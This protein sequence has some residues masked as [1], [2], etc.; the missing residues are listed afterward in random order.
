MGQ[1]RLDVRLIFLI[2]TALFLS[3]CD[4]TSSEQMSVTLRVTSSVGGTVTANTNADGDLELNCGTEGE[5]CSLD[6]PIDS[7]VQLE[8]KADTEFAFDAWEGCASETPIC[9]L[10]VDASRTVSASFVARES[11]EE[12]DPED[13]NPE[14]PEDPEPE[15]PNPEEPEPEEPEPEQYSLEIIL[16][17]AGTGSVTDGSSLDCGDICSASYPAG[18][19]LTLTAEPGEGSIFIGWGE[20]CDNSI[21]LSCSLTLNEDTELEAIFDLEPYALSVAV[22]GS[23]EGTVKGAS[24]A[25]DCQPNCSAELLAGTSVVLTALPETGSSFASWQGCPAPQGDTCGLELDEDTDVSARFNVISGT[26]KTV[27]VP[28]RRSSDDAEEYLK[29]VFVSAK[30]EE[31]FPKNGVDIKSGDLDFV[32]DKLTDADQIVG[33]RFSGLNIP[34]GAT[35][36]KAYIQFRSD[37]DYTNRTPT[38]LFFTA[39]ASAK[40]QT[41]VHQSVGGISSRP[42][43]RTSAVRWDPGL[44]G[45]EGVA[46]ESERSP[47]LSEIVQELVNYPDWD[48][49][50]NAIA[51]IVSGNGY[52]AATSF[53]DSDGEAQL[54]VSYR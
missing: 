35:I 33:L 41:F 3:A 18:T 49:G 1:F 19:E 7:T 43:V 38:R 13:P 17:G 8:A 46:G 23:G 6:V 50:N 40:A 34:K 48:A 44:W 31:S 54:S 53:E 30:Y 15:E 39:E 32:H 10:T 9:E 37:Q 52:R 47:D 24:G 20:A 12:P 21:E 2:V 36:T 29:A 26:E 11:P 25:I 27:R 42:K 22:D 45:Y 14:E 5:L 51:F 28:I 16:D 4:E